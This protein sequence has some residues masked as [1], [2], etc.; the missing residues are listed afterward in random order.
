MSEEKKGLEVLDLSATVARRSQVKPRT[1]MSLTS[2]ESERT[3]ILCQR[4]LDKAKQLIDYSLLDY[5]EMNLVFKMESYFTKH[6]HLGVHWYK[7]LQQLNHR[8][9]QKLRELL[10]QKRILKEAGIEI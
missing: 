5:E 8:Y 10:M 2:E 7:Q 3:A 4:V 6:G 9:S 1:S